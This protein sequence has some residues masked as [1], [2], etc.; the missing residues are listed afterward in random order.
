MKVIVNPNYQGNGWYDPRAGINFFKRDGEI[1]I[2]EG[3]NL[4]N[5]NRYLVLG[6]LISVEEDKVVQQ[7]PELV[8][9]T[10]G[11]LLTEDNVSSEEPSLSEEPVEEVENAEEEVENAEE[12]VENAEEEVVVIAEEE[13]E[14][15]E[16]EVENAEEEV[17]VIAEEAEK[18]ICQFCGKE[19]KTAGGKASHER[20]C[21]KNPDN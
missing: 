20:S 3:T 15:A 5:I 4:E 1:T 17:V 19:L 6:Y 13:V 10:P 18:H 7:E 11:Q 8:V 14:N 12:E 21:K 2:P 9:Q 16:E